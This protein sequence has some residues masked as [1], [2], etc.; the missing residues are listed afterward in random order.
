MA[1]EGRPLTQEGVSFPVPKYTSGRESK[2]S[3]WLCAVVCLEV[4]IRTRCRQLTGAR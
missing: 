1:R 2:V 3:A 4:S